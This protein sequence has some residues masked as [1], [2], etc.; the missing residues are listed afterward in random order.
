MCGSL[1]Q[2]DRCNLLL[3]CIAKED[4]LFIIR[5]EKGKHMKDAITKEIMKKISN[6]V[7]ED[8]VQRACDTVGIGT[9][10]YH[11]LH[12]ML[13]DAL[14][15]RGITE[16]LFPIPHRVRLAKKANNDLIRE[17]LG[18]YLHIEGSMMYSSTR[19]KS[20]GN[21]KGGN[22]PNG[23]KFFDYHQFNNIFVDLK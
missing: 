5:S 20:H 16:N 11:A 12:G 3:G 21:S 14:R 23:T 2:E 15:E 10:A 22:A 9:N 13:K 17:S 4:I 19:A 18:E 6:L 8:D 7:S 1:R